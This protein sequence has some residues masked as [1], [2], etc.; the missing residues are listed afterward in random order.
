MA[1]Q[2]P[3]KN[4]FDCRSP[5]LCA[6]NTCVE[7][8]EGSAC[9]TTDQCILSVCTNRTLCDEYA[10]CKQDGLACIN[11]L[12][13]SD[14]CFG[15]ECF[16]S[17]DC[18]STYYGRI[19]WS[20]GNVGDSCMDDSACRS[21][22]VPYAIWAWWVLGQVVPMD[23]RFW[24]IRSVTARRV[25]PIVTKTCSRTEPTGTLLLIVSIGDDCFDSCMVRSSAT[26][27][28]EPFCD[29][30]RRYLSVLC[31]SIVQLFHSILT[32][33]GWFELREWKLCAL[34]S[35]ACLA[36]SCMCVFVEP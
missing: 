11:R 7:L 17:S 22:R 31:Y 4:T 9:I 10:D 29:G 36:H 25:C 12:F 3:M 26:T 20:E 35:F 34:V 33:H 15:S 30:N 18:Q 5:L 27:R 13:C 6:N 24:K 1:C 14:R 19:G 16:I 32:S 21:V 8:E 2:L 23:E 28:M